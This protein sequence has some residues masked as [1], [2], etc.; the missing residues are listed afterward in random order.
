MLFSITKK[1]SG[2][3]DG[4]LNTW[5]G[6]R[7]KTRAWMKVKQAHRLTIG[8]EMADEKCDRNMHQ[9]VKGKFCL[10]APGECGVE[11]SLRTGETLCR[12]FGID[13]DAICHQIRKIQRDDLHRTGSAVFLQDIE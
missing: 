13:K 11:R 2:R 6:P 7:F 10:S 1:V 12:N 4:P 3:E 5:P 8:D 9:T